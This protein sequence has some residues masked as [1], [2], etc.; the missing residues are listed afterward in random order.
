MMNQ[1]DT[2]QKNRSSPHW[3]SKR[4]LEEASRR[5]GCVICQA[6]RASADRYLHSFL[7]EGMMSPQ[8]RGEF[9]A[10]GGFCRRHFWEAHRIEAEH[11]AEGFGVSI[12]CENL[13]DTLNTD[14]Q[15][16]KKVDKNMAKDRL[17][18]KRRKQ[19]SLNFV[20][21]SACVACRMLSSSEEHLLG[22]LEELLAE[23]S[24][25]RD[26]YVQRGGLCVPHLRAAL[27][28]WQL[29]R[30]REIAVQTAESIIGELLIDLQEFQRKHDYRFKGEPRG[31]EWTSPQRAIELLVGP[32]AER[33]SRSESRAEL[34]SN[35]NKAGG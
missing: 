3:F 23:E 12:L 21:G 7:Y 33:R 16:L 24:H 35:A 6:L 34:I 11:W 18:L 4:A 1:N 5:G 25:F 14:L 31:R 32:P 22:V 28:Q 15:R 20:P 19:V 13:L 8:V 9:L 29:A 27:A 30:A 17:R 10:G 26:E 2:G